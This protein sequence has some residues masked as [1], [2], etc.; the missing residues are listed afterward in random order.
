M[1]KSER[2]LL[3]EISSVEGVKKPNGKYQYTARFADGYSEVIRAVASSK[4]LNAYKYSQKA[5][6]GA[7]SDFA[8]H[9]SFGK[10]PTQYER[11]LVTEVFEIVHF[12]EEV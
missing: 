2:L 7:R 6:A 8:A 4:Y 9:F 5:S 12:I 3:K 10:S 1:T 11:D